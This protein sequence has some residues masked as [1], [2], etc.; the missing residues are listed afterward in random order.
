ML[1]YRL[2]A[3][4]IR[5]LGDWV[6]LRGSCPTYQFVCVGGKE[7]VNDVNE[8]VRMRFLW[9]TDTSDS[10]EG[11]FDVNQISQG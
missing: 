2:P 10:A 7:E 5:D 8:A 1:V 6:P 3:K 4:L 11:L 9:S